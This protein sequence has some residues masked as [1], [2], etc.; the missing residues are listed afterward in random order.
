MLKGYV[1]DFLDARNLLLTLFSWDGEEEFQ[2]SVELRGFFA[3][4][5]PS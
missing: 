1:G 2:A 5:N 3:W 4:V